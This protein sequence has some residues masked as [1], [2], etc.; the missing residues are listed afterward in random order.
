MQLAPF[1]DADTYLSPLQRAE[2]QIARE[3]NEHPHRHPDAGLII[4]LGGPAKLAETLGYDKS[5]GGVQRI[6][7]WMTR[8]IPSAV[9]VERPDL[10]MPHLSAPFAPAANSQGVASFDTFHVCPC[11]HIDD[12][13]V[14]RA[15][16]WAV[17]AL[18][19]MALAGMLP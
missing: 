16:G 8:G 2:H 3:P 13:F 19:V 18:A 1:A 7:N 5:A 15:C 14:M 10:F 12:K 9:K 4:A 6:Q 11:M 17:S